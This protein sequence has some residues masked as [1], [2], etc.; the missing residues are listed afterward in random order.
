MHNINEPRR[1]ISILETTQTHTT[2][3]RLTQQLFNTNM[4]E[5]PKVKKSY[6]SFLPAF[7]LILVALLINYTAS[8]QETPTAPTE[9]ALS[10]HTF[11]TINING[12]VSLDEAQNRI[13]WNPHATGYSNLTAWKVTFRNE[14]EISLETVRGEAGHVAT[15]AWW[16]TSFGS[17]A[18]IPL[19]MTEPIELIATFR[20]NIAAINYEPGKEWLRIALACAVQRDDQSVVYTEMDIWDSPNTL[21]HSTGN[22]HLGGDVVYRGYDVVEYKIDQAPIGKWENYSIYLTRAINSA[23][24]IRPGDLLESVYLV[25]ETIG[26]TTVTVKADDLWITRLA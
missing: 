14:T 19:Y 2:H 4:Q 21:R 10:L 1:R 15:G 18:K 6:T 23:W 5:K 12:D 9:Q 25:V 3:P 20:V 11:G 7:S 16:T 8:S 22:I 26:S 17:E 24:S 13:H